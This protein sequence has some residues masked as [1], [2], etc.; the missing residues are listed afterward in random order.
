M[1]E[2]MKGPWKLDTAEEAGTVEATEVRVEVATP[3]DRGPV[4]ST[5]ADDGRLPVGANTDSKKGGSIPPNG[6][7]AEGL[8]DGV[9]VAAS[10]ATPA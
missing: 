1:P 7:P 6:F 10:E 9:A 2:M 5:I 3:L 4:E 8:A